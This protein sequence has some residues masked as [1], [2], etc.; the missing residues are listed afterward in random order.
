MMT[1]FQLTILFFAAWFNFLVSAFC[2]VFALAY[3]KFPDLRKH[4]LESIQ[5]GDNITHQQDGKF[6]VAL[7]LGLFSALFTANLTLALIAY[8]DI[9]WQHIT[10]MAGFAGIT[11]TL[12]G[13]SWKGF[14]TTKGI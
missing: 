1:T 7:V 9:E 3:F 5:D 6:V 10:V 4:V 14:T 11:F 2:G 12:L 8:K 13:I